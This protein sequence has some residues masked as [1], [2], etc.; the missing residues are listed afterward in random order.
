MVRAVIVQNNGPMAP[1]TFSLS[2]HKTVIGR[3]NKCNIII[4]SMEL[5][6]R[7]VLITL[8]EA[9][10]NIEDLDSANGLFLNGVK[11]H[12]ATMRDGDA[13]QIGGVVFSF[14]EGTV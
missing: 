12:S 5:S 3:G 9:E 8:D 1:R 2:D 10:I 13:F 4:D 7:H 14:R 6:R 11:I